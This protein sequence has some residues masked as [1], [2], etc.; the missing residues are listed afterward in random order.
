MHQGDN[1]NRDSKPYLIHVYKR[2]GLP[3][4]IISDRG[5]QFASHV[6]QE[7]MKLLRIESRMS[8]AH[9]PQTDG[10][11]E[12][13]NQEIQAYL[14][15][16]CA[17]HQD[18][19]SRYIATAEFCHNQATHSVTGTS[20]FYLL[21][22]Y[23]PKAIPTAFEETRVPAVEQRLQELEQARIEALAA[24]DLARIKMQERIKSSN[25]RTFKKGDKVWLEHVS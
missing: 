9:H 15:I 22:G 23:N 16:F 1:S 24:H 18:K 6:F 21:M 2:F 13:V 7:L 14:R 25:P 10:E 20:P 5:P 11:T 3:D 12:R 4:I 17:Y 8:T 19:W